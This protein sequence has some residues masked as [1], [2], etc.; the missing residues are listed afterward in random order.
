MYSDRLA[1]EELTTRI[2]NTKEAKSLTIVMEFIPIAKTFSLV[3]ESS[4]YNSTIDEFYG[5]C[6]GMLATLR[7][8][9]SNAGDTVAQARSSRSTWYMNEPMSRMKNC[10]VEQ[11]W[12][13]LL[14][15]MQRALLLFERKG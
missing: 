4:T 13:D 15:C 3:A 8:P 12:Q 10:D 5:S 7:W 14:P 1:A 2:R 9:F 11:E 6:Q